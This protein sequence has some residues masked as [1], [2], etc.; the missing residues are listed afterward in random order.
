MVIQRVQTLYL[1]LSI[2]FMTAFFF[3]PFGYIKI[4]DPGQAPLLD[5]LTG[6]YSLSTIIPT[7]VAIFFSL[8]AIFLFKALPTQKLFVIFSALI[9]LAEVILVI[10]ILATP[11]VSSDP[12]ASDT[13]IWGGGGLL[14][15]GALIVDIAA[16]RSISRD[17]KLLRSYDRL[18]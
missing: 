17:Q 1:L 11:Y 3:L 12:S 8:V 5:P 14:L 4:V 2:A 16:Y 9:S 15:I 18:R 6:T 10:Y 7:S 13:A